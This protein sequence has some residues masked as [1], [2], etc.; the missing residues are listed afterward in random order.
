MGVSVC[1]CV[2]EEENSISHLT[3]GSHYMFAVAARCNGQY[4]LTP[5]LFSIAIRFSFMHLQSKPAAAVL[6]GPI[7]TPSARPF[8]LR[9][10]IT[11]FR[12]NAFDFEFHLAPR[13]SSVCGLVDVCHAAADDA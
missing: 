9:V 12:A 1:V 2:W 11:Y 6:A 4:R 5:I 7:A 8:E 10:S 13:L 3:F